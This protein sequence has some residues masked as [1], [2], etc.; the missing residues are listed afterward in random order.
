MT[1]TDAFAPIEAHN[2]S[3]VLYETWGHLAPQPRQTYRG[4]MLF[5]ESNYG[6]L[7]LLS[8]Q[9]EGL[10]DSPWLYNDMQAY[11][12]AYPTQPG[13]L[14][15]FSGTYTKHPDGTPSFAGTVT[16]HSLERLIPPAPPRS[17]DK[18]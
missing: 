18:R 14:Y 17:T 11:I 13:L 1:W 16:A 12:S 9:W 7:T 10:D 4:Q 15:H 8:S 2:R 6:D 5:I 3:V